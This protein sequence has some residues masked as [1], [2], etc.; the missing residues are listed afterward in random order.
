ML[1]WGV[2]LIGIYLMWTLRQ[3]KLTLHLLANILVKCFTTVVERVKLFLKRS[4][5]FILLSTT[6][7]PVWL[8]WGQISNFWSFFNSFGFFLCLKKGQ[9]KFGFFGLFWRIRFLW[10]FGRFKGD[11]GRFLGTGIFLD[12]VSGHRMINVNWKLCTRI[13]NFSFAISCF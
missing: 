1:A 8:F 10:R 12:S 5:L 6:G 13:Y 9:M 2:Y 3:A 7:L 11:F 4:C